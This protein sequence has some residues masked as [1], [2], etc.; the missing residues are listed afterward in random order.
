MK[1]FEYRQCNG[2]HTL[3]FQHSRTRGVT[4]LIVY[5]DNIIIIGNNKDEARRLEDH[6]LKHF[7][8]KRSWTFEIF[9]LGIEISK[10]SRALL[11]T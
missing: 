6:L 8:A 2:D 10:S 3:F 1:L 9:F 5:L 11:L 4:I 7:E